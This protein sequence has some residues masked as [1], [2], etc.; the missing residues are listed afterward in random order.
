MILGLTEEQFTE[1]CSEMI[2]KY[3][4]YGEKIGRLL[5]RPAAYDFQFSKPVLRQYN[6]SLAKTCLEL[7]I[8]II[9]HQLSP[10][11]ESHEVITRGKTKMLTHEQIELAQNMLKQ[12]PQ[13][14]D[15]EIAETIGCCSITIKNIRLERNR[16]NPYNLYECKISGLYRNRKRT[17]PE[18]V[19]EVRERLDRGERIIDIA[20]EM[21][22]SDG[23]IHNIKF[24]KGKYAVGHEDIDRRL[25]RI[26]I[27]KEKV[28]EVRNLLENTTISLKNIGKKVGV[29]HLFVTKVRDNVGHLGMDDWQTPE[30]RLP[31]P[32]TRLQ[33][34]EELGLLC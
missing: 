33:F 34:D 8:P 14:T 26:Q 18:E 15:E 3:G 24:Q 12:Q 2:I 32:S 6:E 7:N 17:T 28:L 22:I 31:K 19:Q 9:T 11:P 10:D 21:H 5:L 1:L 23:T 27:P 25:L 20:A 30:H 13:P 4:T 16:Y 29:S